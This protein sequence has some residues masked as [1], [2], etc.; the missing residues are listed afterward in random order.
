M[1]RCTWNSLKSMIATASRRFHQRATRMEKK[2]EELGEERERE[3]ECGRE[4]CAAWRDRGVLERIFDRFLRSVAV[5]IS[6]GIS[7]PSAPSRLP[8]PRIQ[9]IRDDVIGAPSIPQID[10]DTHV[11]N[12]RQQF[13]PRLACLTALCRLACRW[14]AITN[15]TT[16][17]CQSWAF[18]RP[19]RHNAFVPL[20]SVPSSSSSVRSHRHQGRERKK[21]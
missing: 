18:Q 1:P 4:R 11:R 13:L 6:C 19:D 9:L 20:L 10:T 14:P 15:T 8:W 16:I 12:S 17:T 2:S 7:A 3:R 21:S 5:P